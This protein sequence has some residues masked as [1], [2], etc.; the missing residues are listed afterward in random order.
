MRRLLPLALLATACAAASDPS[1]ARLTAVPQP[2]GPTGPFS[3]YTAVR[4]TLADA[5]QEK[6]ARE[7]AY[8]STPR[9]GALHLGN[10]SDAIVTVVLD[11]PEV[12]KTSFLYVDVNN[13]ND[14]TNDSGGAWP[15]GNDVN[16]IRDLEIAVAYQAEAATATAGYFMRFYR[17]KDFSQREALR[18]KVL[19]YRANHREGQIELEG[20]SYRIGIADDDTDGLFDD[21]DAT[22]M[23]IDLDRDGNLDGKPGS[24][25][26][27]KANEPFH[28]GGKS[29]K[30][31][32]IAPAG[33]SIAVGP[34]D[35]EVPPRTPPGAGTPDPG[36]TP[37]PPGGSA[38]TPDPGKTPDPAKGPDPSKA[39]DPGPAKTP[40][41]PS[42]D[43]L[44]QR[45]NDERTKPAAQRTATLRQ[46]GGLRTREAAEFLKW[47]FSTET[48][49]I[50]RSACATA[51]GNNATPEAFQGL[52][53]Q[54]PRLE[55]EAAVLA[56][57]VRAL[58]RFGTREAL[59]HVVTAYQE[60][61]KETAVRLAAAQTV[62]DFGA[63]ELAKDVERFY[64]EALADEYAMVQAEALRQLADRKDKR[65]IAAAR[66]ALESPTAALRQAAIEP[67]KF[68]GTQEV[69]VDLFQA[70]SKEADETVKRAMIDALLTF[71]DPAVRKYVQAQG[72]AHKDPAIRRVAV[73]LLGRSQ[74]KSA[75]PV[76]LKALRDGDPLVRLAA[77]DALVE[78][79]A[80]EAVKELLNLAGADDPALA[81]AAIEGLGS[82][83]A[84]AAEV[85]PKLLALL[86]SRQPAVLLAAA[87]ALGR[88]HAGEALQ[89]LIALLGHE[90][91]QVR[92]GAI[93]A[94]FKLRRKEAIPALIERLAK[95]DG[96]LRNDLAT[97]LQR[98][99]GMKLGY[100][101]AVWRRWWEDNKD[102][103]VPQEEGADE[104]AEAADK[105]T[106]YGIPVVSKRVC[107]LLDISGSMSAAQ[108][109]P[110]THLE[111]EK[112]KV[113]RLEVAKQELMQTV[114]LLGKD[115]LF[116]IVMFD[117][118]QEPWQ[119]TL[120]PADPGRKQEANT[121]ILKQNPRGG[122]NIYD[123]LEL[124]MRDDKVDTIFLLSDGQPG[125]GKFIQPGDIL[126][127]IRKLNRARKVVIHTICIG[128]ANQFMEDLAKQNGGIAVRR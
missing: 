69:F 22:G 10:G 29:W 63:E 108:P 90:A 8:A 34:S 123:P 77:V 30:V 47:V 101:A 96:R 74:D 42:L 53:A 48:D 84:N 55:K 24:W 40:A 78:L 110:G 113:T 116:N 80:K 103:F 27:F 94:L 49:L 118:R 65:V 104:I 79:G 67:L 54:F 43:E 44:K 68:A 46:I 83:E 122:T 62:G 39:P 37:D 115:V 11:E 66:K 58:G 13:D 100:D 38:G 56:A 51:L 72:L 26:A 59:Q 36:K 85:T 52:V 112:G 20:V 126:R 21:L 2:S 109:V 1:Q 89:P 88:L 73:A 57:V 15:K 64:Y 106:Y 61:E 5:P 127:E 93:E 4:I 87:N 23:A 128:T 18:D 60:A 107:F 76:L 71:N 33:D 70:A 119:K 14:L 99:T 16:F 17:F 25:E 41:G 28:A 117:D 105:T 35:V 97:V 91:W 98:L 86:K 95:E 6:L 7:P 81:A 31:L 124:A 50:L 45:Y 92:A 9:Y 82:L 114:N 111:G 3:H 120:Q 125:S 102:T 12:G 19:C 75:L 121:F 32:S